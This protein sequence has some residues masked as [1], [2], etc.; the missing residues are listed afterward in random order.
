MKAQDGSVATLLDSN[1]P[2]L[3][4]IVTGSRDW[5][6]RR[7]VWNP[8]NQVRRGYPGRRIL[9]RNGKARKGVDHLVSRWTERYAHLG[10]EEDPHR[11]D[12]DIHGNQ[13]GFLRNQEMVDAGA[14]FLM[15]WANPCTKNAPWCP[16]VIHPSHG[17]A[18]C[19]DR[20][21]EAG[22][23]VLFSPLGMSW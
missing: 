16:K 19:V 6:D 13:A 14:D 7:S 3:C 1:L 10:I 11:A 4:L 2:S 20:A 18:H 15:A 12:W 21:K 23:R 5:L 8:L 22:I 9:I 17:T